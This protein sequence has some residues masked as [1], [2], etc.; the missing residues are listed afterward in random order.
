MDKILGKLSVYKPNWSWSKETDYWLSKQCI[1]RTLNF[2]CGKS[3][4]GTIK[5]DIDKQ[6]Y[7]DVIADLLNIDTWPKEW[8]KFSFDTIICDPPFEFYGNQ[9]MKWLLPL[10]ERTKKR[11]ILSTPAYMIYL[12][13]RIWKREFYLTVNRSNFMIRHWQIFDRLN[14]SLNEC[15][16]SKEKTHV[17]NL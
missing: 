10:A 6:F 16:L 3:T 7:P 5:A 8:T 9:R 15:S 11:L 17:A 2:P 1:G 13:K 14:V 12:P 4:V